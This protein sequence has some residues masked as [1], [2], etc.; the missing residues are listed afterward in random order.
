MKCWNE[1]LSTFGSDSGDVLF[2]QLDK[3]VEILLFQL[4]TYAVALPD[5]TLV[6]SPLSSISFRVRS[7][8]E[9]LISGQVLAISDLLILPSFCS[10]DFLLQISNKSLHRNCPLSTQKY[11]LMWL[12]S[13]ST[14]L[15]CRECFRLTHGFL[16]YMNI[17]TILI[18]LKKQIL[19]FS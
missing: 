15:Q 5:P 11:L 1:N 13:T 16:C 8:I 2:L 6:I 14:C 18:M 7:I 10:K 9:I 12:H 19:F 4:F 17:E 3:T